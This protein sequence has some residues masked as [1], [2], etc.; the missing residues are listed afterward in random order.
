MDSMRS[1][2]TAKKNES[3]STMNLRH[4][5]LQSFISVSIIVGIEGAIVCVCR[6]DWVDAFLSVYRDIV[7]F[8]Q[9]C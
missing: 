7:K 1:T 4:V 3:S 6:G 8:Y 2:T 9:F 5:H